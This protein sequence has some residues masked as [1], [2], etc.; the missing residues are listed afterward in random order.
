M[1]R[2]IPLIFLLF[3]PLLAHAATA[4]D[5]LD[6]I[7]LAR[8]RPSDYAAILEATTREIPGIDEREVEEASAFLRRQSPLEPLQCIPGLISSAQQQVDEQG[9]TGEI[10]H[11]APDGSD[12]FSRI[13]RQGQWS[14]H[15]GE[16]ISYGY[17]DARTIVILQIIDQGVPGRGHRRNI[18]S[19][20]FRVAGAARGPHARYGTMCVIDFAEGFSEKG[21]GPVDSI[22]AWGPGLW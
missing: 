14:G 6:E 16:N 19:R 17:D 7:N 21:T 8:T 4:G 10:G 18:F 22:V 13:S 1:H 12:P 11:R 3:A 5:V 9:P 15:A 2:L 20:D